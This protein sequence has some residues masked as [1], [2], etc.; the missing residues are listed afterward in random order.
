M[1]GNVKAILTGTGVIFGL[2]LILAI[3][4]KVYAESVAQAKTEPLTAGEHFN[5]LFMGVSLGTFFIGGLIVGFMEE[6]LALG[7]PVIAAALA[8][9]LA[10][11]VSYVFNLPDNIFL[12]AYAQEGAWGSFVMTVAIGLVAT[13]AGGLIGERIRTPAA[14][15]PI[16]RSVVVIALALVLT[17]PF[18][19]LIPYGLPWYIAVI[20]TLVILVLVGVGYYLFTQGPTFEQSI[21]EISI[22]P[23][24]HRES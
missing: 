1:K 22:S 11:L 17:A 21:E 18:Y 7:A 13:V 16:A 3:L 10:S 8:M 6:R 4:I 20:A 2:Q 15:D 23:E 9:A 14:D 12:V 24:R 5:M 19:F